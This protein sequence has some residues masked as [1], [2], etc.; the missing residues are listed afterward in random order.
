MAIIRTDTMPTAIK[1][2]YVRQL[3]L[4][5]LPRLLY[6]RWGKPA[7]WTGY[8]QAEIR[9]YH[10]LNPVTTALT[11]GTT[12][13]EQSAPT[14]STVTL[15]PEWYGAWIGYT[16]KLQICT[17][18]QLRLVLVQVQVWIPTTTRSATLTS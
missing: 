3:Q 14:I 5:A 12:P 18:V 17:L 8:D 16:D 9:K 13:G 2:M 7:T 1:A 15:V 10:G 11:E 6:A 4:R